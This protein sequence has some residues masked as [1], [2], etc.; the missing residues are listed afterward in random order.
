MLKAN[1]AIH[2]ADLARDERYIQKRDPEI[3]FLSRS[4]RNPT[5]GLEEW[6]EW[7]AVNQLLIC[8]RPCS[9]RSFPFVL[10]KRTVPT[11]STTGFIRAS[12]AERPV[13]LLF[14]NGGRHA[15]NSGIPAR[16]D[17]F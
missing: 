16:C 6:D 4:A 11:L 3:A 13:A 10:F 15:S 7:F 8:R 12:M 2:V 17:R 1:A 14:G 5:T 9:N